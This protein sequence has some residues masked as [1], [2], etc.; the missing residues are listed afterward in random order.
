MG[1]I[2]LVGT[3]ELRYSR[4]FGDAYYFPRYSTI[5]FFSLFA[6]PIIKALVR[7]K[8]SLRSRSIFR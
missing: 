6:S 3:A 2:H 8:V 5:A 4:M 7:S 1:Q